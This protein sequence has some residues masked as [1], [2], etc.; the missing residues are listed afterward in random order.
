MKP[1]EAH[2][3]IRAACLRRPELCFHDS[4]VEIAKERGLSIPNY[5]GFCYIA[6]HVFAILTGAEVWA[7]ESGDHY[8]NRLDGK[9]WDLT[10]EQFDFEYQYE[11]GHRVPKKLTKRAKEL[12]NECNL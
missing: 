10:K 6:S 12:Y 5:R 1:Q 3:L 9:I 4:Y 7:S 8:W 2:D 11:Y